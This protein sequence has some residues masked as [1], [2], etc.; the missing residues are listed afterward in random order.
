MFATTQVFAQQKPLTTLSGFEVPGFDEEG[1]ISFLLYGDLA[2]IMPNNIVRITNLRI[3]YY[4]DKKVSMRVTSP[5]CFYYENS[6]IAKSDYDVKIEQ[7]K[8]VVTGTGFVW[9]S[10][11][12]RLEI[13][14]NAKVVIKDARKSIESGEV[15]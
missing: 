2:E 6:K 8:M 10:E 11:D 14:N 7:E 1:N 3:D 15:K 9:S 5:F 4:E 12:E 13:L